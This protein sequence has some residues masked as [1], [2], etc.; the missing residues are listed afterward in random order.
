[1]RLDSQLNIKIN[2]EIKD[3]FE[4][5]A[6]QDGRTSSDLARFLIEK[7]TQIHPNARLIVEKI[8]KECEDEKKA[9][10]YCHL[11]LFKEKKPLDVRLYEA[12]TKKGGKE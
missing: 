2:P 12:I 1:M 11:I 3:E 4:K 6:K 5:L 9:E 10:E 7:Y 8:L